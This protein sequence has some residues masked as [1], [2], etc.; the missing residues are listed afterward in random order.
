ML[1][2]VELVSDR[3]TKAIL[4]KKQVSA[5]KDG[6]HAAGMLIT[7]SGTHG[8]YLR[9]QPPLCITAGE[10]D[11]FVTALRTVLREVRR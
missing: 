5:I 7:V 2:G 10:I 11:R 4:P 9:L 6:L 3:A 1:G 8:N